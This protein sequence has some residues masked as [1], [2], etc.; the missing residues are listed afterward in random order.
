MKHK[1]FIF[2]CVY[3]KKYKS[4]IIL[5]KLCT[6]DL[7]LKL[8]IL[9][10]TSYF[11]MVVCVCIYDKK[12]V[13]RS[14]NSQVSSWY[15]STTF[16]L[17]SRLKSI[18]RCTKLTLMSKF[19]V[20]NVGCSLCVCINCNTCCWPNTRW[21]QSSTRASFICL[22]LCICCCCCCWKTNCLRVHCH[23][24]SAQIHAKISFQEFA[25]SKKNERKIN[26]RR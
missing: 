14:V 16:R 13:L 12:C 22:C 4:R 19:I 25:I 20:K 8:H 3:T 11:W 23:L 9:Y 1:L 17:V 24:N 7:V 6:R 21:V 10:T 26:E 18:F 15:K 5:V 2:P